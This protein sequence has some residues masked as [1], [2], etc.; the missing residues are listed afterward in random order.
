MADPKKKRVT[1]S[2]FG[3]RRGSKGGYIKQLEEAGDTRDQSERD[4]DAV[5]EDL[6]D[7]EYEYE[8]EG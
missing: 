4:K 6:D 2:Y 3:T 1:G 7:D 5:F 8:Y